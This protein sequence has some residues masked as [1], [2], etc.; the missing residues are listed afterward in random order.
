MILDSVKKLNEE[1]ILKCST[2]YAP[3]CSEV[4]VEHFNTLRFFTLEEVLHPVG[5]PFAGCL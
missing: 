5:R 2:R 1:C 3:P 4:V